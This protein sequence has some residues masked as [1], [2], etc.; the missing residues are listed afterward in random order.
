M[1]QPNSCP[2]DKKCAGKNCSN[3]GVI[4]LKLK[5]IDK[6]GFFCKICSEKLLQLEIIDI[7]EK[8]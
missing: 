2:K 4:K 3:S 5:Y 7:E 6:Y 1:L 8:I